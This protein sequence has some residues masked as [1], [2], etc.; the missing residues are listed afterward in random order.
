MTYTTPPLRHKTMKEYTM[1]LLNRFV[2]PHFLNGCIEVLVIFDDPDRH[3]M[4]PK[5][6]ERQR[7][8]KL[9]RPNIN[10]VHATFDDS[11]PP[12]SKSGGVLKCRECKHKFTVRCLHDSFS[13]PHS[14]A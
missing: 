6:V 12:S 7:R 10:H 5:T 2:T 9:A 11:L 1:F 4:S 8:D 13:P 3:E 14:I